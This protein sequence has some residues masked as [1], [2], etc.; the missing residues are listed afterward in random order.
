MGSIYQTSQ[1]WPP[2][3]TLPPYYSHLEVRAF[4]LARKVPILETYLDI[5]FPIWEQCYWKEFGHVK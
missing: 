2:H 5:E 3:L 4:Y 1:P